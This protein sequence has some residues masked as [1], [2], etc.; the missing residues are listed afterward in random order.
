VDLLRENDLFSHLAIHILLLRAQSAHLLGQENA[1]ARYYRAG[2][3]NLVPGSE[4]G[5][6]FQIGLL[7]LTG[8]L[9]DVSSRP[10][11]ESQ[12]REIVE[13][14]RLSTNSALVGIGHFLSSLIDTGAHAKYVQ[15]TFIGNRL[16]R[17]TKL[18]QAFQV[19]HQNADKLLYVLLY[20]FLASVDVSGEFERVEKQLET[21]K[22]LAKS[23]GG[24]DRSDGVGQGSLGVWFS[25]KLSSEYLV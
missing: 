24:I 13:K 11:V 15:S 21:G 4:L 8:Q 1:A 17:R 10:E 6:V 14:V 12:V 7:G 19:S 2:L 5:L 9:E 20:A 18:R 22:E 3:A 25:R 16:T 23:M